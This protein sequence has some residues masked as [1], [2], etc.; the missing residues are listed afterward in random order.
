MLVVAIVILLFMFGGIVDLGMLFLYRARTQQLAD[1]AALAGV[2]L[3]PDAGEAKIRAEDIAL[4]NTRDINDAGFVAG[5]DVEA[6]NGCTTVNDENFFGVTVSAP[7]R[8]MFASLWE[9]ISGGTITVA[10]YA[11]AAR[12]TLDL[13]MV[14]DTSGFVKLPNP[15]TW[16][17]PDPPADPLGI[18]TQKG[19][20][21]ATVLFEEGHANRIGVIQYD[22]FAYT[23]LPLSSSLETITAT[24]GSFNAIVASDS[25]KMPFVWDPFD[26]IANWRF[27][28][29]MHYRS[30]PDPGAC[31]NCKGWGFDFPNLAAAT[32]NANQE[33]LT[34]SDATVKAVVFFIAG[35]PLQPSPTHSC[36]FL[37]SGGRNFQTGAPNNGNCTLSPYR[38]PALTCNT[39]CICGGTIGLFPTA[40]QENAFW[41]IEKFRLMMSGKPIY[42]YIVFSPPNILQADCNLISPGMGQP[43]NCSQF[44]FPD[45]DY[46]WGDNIDWFDQGDFLDL[47][48]E[49]L[50]ESEGGLDDMVDQ[51]LIRGHY[52][53]IDSEIE[54][55]MHDL[56][57]VVH[58]RLV[59]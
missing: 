40:F 54:I 16:T 43:N 59:G 22:T 11:E 4:L 39:S 51:G 1:A 34:G 19:Q 48:E 58:S 20:Q 13:M 26:A 8:L 42:Y 3:C 7:V 57:Q 45:T 25:E 28:N 33:V 55:L 14:F 50:V 29:N 24:I 17:W 23:R 9:S 2:R 46:T 30:T 41:A 12:G 31:P 38:P 21:T 18:L 49:I 32:F 36:G 47:Y 44:V 5:L 27:W 37:C 10:S 52:K 56:R 53:A 35:I 15:A 6:P